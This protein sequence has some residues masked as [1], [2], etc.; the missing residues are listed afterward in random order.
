MICTAS[1]TILHPNLEAAFNFGS[2]TNLSSSPGAVPL[3]AWICAC[4]R[5]CVHALG[6]WHALVRACVGACM[7]WLVHALVCACVGACMRCACMRWWVR[8]YAL[9][10][11][12]LTVLFRCTE[13]TWVHLFQVYS[14][15][16]AAVNGALMQ[17]AYSCALYNVTRLHV[18]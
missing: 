11:A 16:R 10:R 6:A 18:P 2:E 17:N 14:C 15:K 1:Y 9:V 13:F 3:R 4:M 5:W 8:V 7:R 12:W